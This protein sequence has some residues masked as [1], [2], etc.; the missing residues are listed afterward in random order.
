MAVHRAIPNGF[1]TG[2]AVVQKH[3]QSS[4]RE[5]V[6]IIDA[7]AGPCSTIFLAIPDGQALGVHGGRGLESMPSWT[8]SVMVL[9]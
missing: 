8:G 1:T 7:R 3:G 5:R 4:S 9:E 2:I 6:E